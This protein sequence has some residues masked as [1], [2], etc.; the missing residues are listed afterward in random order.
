MD[1]KEIAALVTNAIM[2]LSVSRYGFNVSPDE[3]YLIAEE[4]AKYI[5]GRLKLE[6][7]DRIA[8]GKNGQQLGWVYPKEEQLKRISKCVLEH[9][10]TCCWRSDGWAEET[11]ALI[12]KDIYEALKS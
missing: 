2:N 7:F 6:R 4:S 11:A 8:V 1:E 10:N 9:V 3:A 12:S 5:A